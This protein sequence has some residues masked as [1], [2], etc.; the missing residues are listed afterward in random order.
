MSGTDTAFLDAA[1]D[2]AW[3]PLDALGEALEALGHA[4]GLVAG[5]AQATGL[6]LDARTDPDEWIG[7]AASQLGMEAVPVSAQVRDLGSFLS[8]GGPALIR[9]SHRG[10][11]GFLALDGKQ[12]GGPAFLCRDGR[13][14]RLPQDAVEA[15]LSRH[16]LA[17]LHPEV[18]RV[19]DAADV[20]PARRDRI[21]AA[22][23][24]QRIGTE[25]IAGLTLLRLPASADFGKQFRHAGLPLRLAQVTGLLLLFYGA[26]LWGWDLIGGATLSGRLDWGWLMAWL[27]LA[28]T[29]MPWRL[30]AGWNEA[31]FA[32]ETGRLVKSRLLAGALALPPDVVK[33]QGVG[34]LISKVME[35]QALE[36][37][38]LGGSF[39]V[40]GG[41]VELGFA[42][43]VLRIG[44]APVLH[45][46]LLGMFA[47]LTLVMS[48]RYHRRI[49]EW[50]ARRLG[51]THYL[52]EAMVGHRTRLAQERANRR[53][54]SEDAQLAGYLDTARKMD[55]T[56][57][58]FGSV[59]GVA[60]SIAALLAMGPALAGTPA[61]GAGLLAISL[62]GMM[63]GQRALGG[64]GGGLASLSRAGFA[65]GQVSTIFRAG[66]RVDRTG[67][68]TAARSAMT[69]RSGP[70][71]EARAL[72][73]A[74]EGAGTPVLERASLAIMAGDRVLIEGPSGGGKSTLA[75]L[76]TGLRR[77]D[78]GLL[79]LDGL[80][81]PTIGD[82][83]H[84]RVTAAPQFHEN[85]VLSGTLAF[86]L[87][88]GR[89]WPP[90]DADLADAEALCERL[91]L[92]DL[93]R[94]MPGG[95]H[96]RV[97]ETGWQL[98]HGE[99]SRIFL[100]RAL[101]QRADV[102]ILDESFASLDPATMNQ[103]LE[104]ALAEAE[105]L[106]VI[107]HP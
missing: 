97:G 48:L 11:A 99:R 31:M 79:L 2:A 27:L 30:L 53:D 36:G 51:L 70:V 16:L 34:T 25:A 90:S 98:S 76:L 21:A 100:A 94:R 52:V 13:R 8:Y 87:L 37:M 106:V 9:Q 35:S 81:R 72:R 71:L 29:M 61:P 39:A 45:P 54:A 24:R 80:D 69:E 28:F 55:G 3:W 67:L 107:A 20:K 105:T 68:P 15:V 17:A 26:E 56:A 33:R 1:M 43:W 93:L 10:A 4:H 59:L 96:Q 77:A 104:T 40:L 66:N 91:G 47:L 41:L 60:W 103:C 63:L 58:R 92:G 12:R 85:H 42:A 7:W 46:V 75:S 95:L 86:N 57:L 22:M 23:I 44:A 5:Q 74:H 19:L 50:T 62:G 83:W 49:A 88:M 6:P 38:A 78:G 32:L 101:L 14:Q 89:H 65:W 18:A 84:A 73:Y 64:I 102:T 82:A